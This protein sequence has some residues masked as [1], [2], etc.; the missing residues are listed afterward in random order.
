MDSSVLT[1]WTGPFLLYGY[2]ISFYYYRVLQKFLNLVEAVW[3][4][5]WRRVLR[6]QILVYIV[7]QSPI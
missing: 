2:L 7:C 3:T 6:R 4:P 5:I 1:L